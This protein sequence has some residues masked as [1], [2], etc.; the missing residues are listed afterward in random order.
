MLLFS[1]MGAI[2]LWLWKVGLT[3]EYGL[4]IGLVLIVGAGLSAVQYIQYRKQAPWPLPG[5]RASWL[6]QAI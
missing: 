5:Q 4:Y 6:T 2:E 1:A 3:N